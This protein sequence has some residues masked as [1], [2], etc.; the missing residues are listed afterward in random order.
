[1]KHQYFSFKRMMLAVVLVATLA[2]QTFAAG[3]LGIKGEESASIGILIKDLKT[4]KTI[5]SSNE[6]M[7]LVPA[8]ITKAL[9]SASALQ[10]LDNNFTF[11]TKVT[12]YGK[13][14]KKGVVSGILAVDA[15]G[16]PT[17]DSEFFKDNRGFCDSI[18]SWMK[19]KGITGFKGQIMVKN[20]YADQG[21][22]DS[23]TIDDTPWAYGAGF[24]G[25]NYKDNTSL[26]YPATGVAKPPIPGLVIK[27][28]FRKR[29]SYNLVRGV[30]S[31]V[32]T[33][34]ASSK[35]FKNVKWS[36]VTTIPDPS[37]SFCM[38]MQATLNKAGIKYV[39]D[40]SV[41]ASKLPVMDSLVWNSP[42][43][44]EIL[45]SL[46]T[47]SDNLFAEGILR[48]FCPDGSRQDCIDTELQLWNKN[49]I[50]TSYITIC[51]GSGLSRATRFSPKFIAAI[52]D[53]M[54]KSPRGGTY[55]SLFPLSG[56]DGTMRNFAVDTP[57]EGRL[58]FKTGSMSGVQTYAG[59]ILD[60]K[61]N[62]TH[63][64]VFMA[65]SF[66][67][68]RAELRKAIQNLILRRV[69]GISEK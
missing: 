63:V 29:G 61:G 45:R 28:R 57:L 34:Y 52:L 2:S 32:L 7:A 9:T 8:S 11:K 62:P 60:E 35:L 54:I 24:Y 69:L 48:S 5:V 18:A 23:W 65:N 19:S 17:L 21:Q 16:D 68:S 42:K 55:K 13:I 49:N 58:A 39:S 20:D 37:A 10:L 12:L 66:K 6:E 53:Y 3:I 50:S 47:R 1:M 26:L 44:T 27:R 25:F 31:P 40:S 22:V 64:A 33:I 56:R 59:Y 4:G 67:C 14:N 15:C 36:V 30:G 41:D 38:E 46:M 51:D 43:L